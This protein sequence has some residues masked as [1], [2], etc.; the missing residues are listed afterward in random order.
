MLRAG[1]GYIT[2]DLHV[3]ELDSEF[4]MAGWLWLAD[5]V[6]DDGARAGAR[7]RARESVVFEAIA[8]RRNPIVWKEPI[9]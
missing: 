4:A 9:M 8:P 2:Y 3:L 1:L 7:A 5:Y 6:V